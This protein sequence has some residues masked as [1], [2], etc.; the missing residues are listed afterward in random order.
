M[1]GT[2]LAP[3]QER[4]KHRKARPWQI[5]DASRNPGQERIGA[6]CSRSLKIQDPHTPGTLVEI[7]EQKAGAFWTAFFP[8]PP[9]ADLSDRLIPTDFPAVI[10]QEIQ[11]AVQGAKAGKTPGEDGIL[12]S[13]WHKLIEIPVL[14]E[15]VVQLF[16]A[17]INTG[18][19][20]SHF[21]R[22]ITVVLRKQGKT[23]KILQTCRVVEHAREV[24][25]AVAARRISYAA[26]IHGLLPQTHLGGRKGVSTDHAIHTIID[27]SKTAWG[28]GFFVVSLLMLDV[29]GAYDNVAHERLLHNLKKRRMGHFVPWKLRAV[30]R[31]ADQWAE[32]HA[33]VF[34]QKKYALVHFM[35]TREVDPRCTSLPLRGHTVTATRTAERYLGYWLDPGLEFHHHCEKALTEAGVSLHALRSLAGSTRGAS[36]YATRKI[37][38]A[39]IIP[40]MLFGVCVC[41][42]PM[43]ISKY[44]ARQISLPF[45]AVQKQAASLISGAFRTTA[46]EALNVELHLPPISVH[47]NRLV[48]ETAL[49]LRRGPLFAVPPTML[50]PWTPYERDWAGWT[51]MEA[52]AWKTDGCLTTPL[53]TLKRNWESR[54]G[55]VLAPWQAPPDVSR[56]EKLR[57][58]DGRIG[59]A[60]VVDLE[61]QHAHNQMGGDMPST[62]YAAK[63]RAIEMALEMVLGSSTYP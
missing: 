20:P 63:L 19:N 3:G 36:L 7:V 4:N 45:T 25:E 23:R 59:A 8:K 51:S 39:V 35:N 16:N 17:C 55:F 29:S 2:D 44:K 32:K 41:Y 47:M 52:Q 12:N 34:D 21:Q 28:E 33:S 58:I 54:K 13:L 62:V 38:Q 40:Q 60:A 5:H 22:S 31:K 26:E 10:A 49:R 27:G 1:V 37:Y 30:C 6:K 48:K 15:T 24:L 9:P 18:Y 61:D 46:A 57:G 11:E 56:T 53:G 42:Q 43:L 50:R 14:L